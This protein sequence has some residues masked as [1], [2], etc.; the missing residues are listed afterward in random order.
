MMAEIPSPRGGDTDQAAPARLT[1]PLW[2]CL[3]AGE[4]R[5]GSWRHSTAC[6]VRGP[7]WRLPP[8]FVPHGVMAEPA[9]ETG[10]PSQA[11]REAWQLR[12]TGL[13]W[14]QIGEQLGISPQLARHRGLRAEALGA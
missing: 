13:N 14:R 3:C 8:R 10:G 7:G 12:Q 2:G 11:Q 4:E 1:G 6:P 9:E 5:R